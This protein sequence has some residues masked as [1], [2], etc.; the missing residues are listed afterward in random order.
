MDPKELVAGRIADAVTAQNMALDK[1][2]LSTYDAAELAA[3]RE[4]ELIG[5]M[6]VGGLLMAAQIGATQ[7]VTQ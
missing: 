4:G 1:A 7:A 2:L 5:A 6:K 3:F